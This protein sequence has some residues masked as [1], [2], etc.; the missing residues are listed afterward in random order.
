MEDWCGDADIHGHLDV[1]SK[2]WIVFFSGN[3]GLVNVHLP[4]MGQF[5]RGF[6]EEWQQHVHAAVSPNRIG[7]IASNSY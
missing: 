1:T 3:D 2:L 5:H 6:T 7:G 4:A